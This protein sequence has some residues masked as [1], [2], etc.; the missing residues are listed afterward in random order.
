[1]AKRHKRRTWP[2]VVLFGGLLLAALFYLGG[3]WYFA[4]Q[5][6]EDALKAEPYDATSLQKGTI[7]AIE[8]TEETKT[9][10]LLPDEEDRDETKFDHAIVGLVIGDSNI[11]V[12]PAKVGED[13]SEVRAVREIHGESPK[14][15]DRYGLTRDVWSTPGNAGLK[16]EEVE[17]ATLEGQRYS[18]WRVR[19]SNSDN[20]A[21]LTHGKGASRAE[22][23]R[24][25]RTLHRA[26]YSLLI[27]TYQN[28]AGA[29]AT[30]DGMVHYGR[31]E[32]KEVEGG[33]QYALD[34]GA[35]EIVLGGVS[36][37]GAV[38]LGF[39]ALSPMAN[40]VSGVILDAPASSLQDVIDAAADFRELPVVGLPIPE[41][42]EATAMWIVAARY[43]VDYGAVDYTGMKDLVRSPLLTIQGSDDRTVPKAV[44][45]RFMGA[46]GAGEGGQYL[47]VDR[48]DHVLSWNL[49]PKAYEDKVTKF[50]RALK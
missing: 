16:A 50:V 11:V 3:G 30:D 31:T 34:Q 48:A 22:M 47:V 43:G 49:G 20:W 28:D 42:L 45:D 13:G 17:F 23:L 19:A 33:V 8:V 14:P 29:P 38:T 10:T 21:V 5:V 32:W 24:M 44:N 26:G 36:H 6:Y 35:K 9:V 15:G 25:G 12:G 7:T 4:G 2:W 37:G 40:Q 41:S 1:M 46:D 27:I 18:A 39:L